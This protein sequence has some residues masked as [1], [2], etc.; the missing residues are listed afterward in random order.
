MQNITY[1][2]INN[3]NINIDLYNFINNEVVPGLNIKAEFFFTS[4]QKI[5]NK[6][7]KENI[8]LLE[9]RNNMQQKIDNWHI[10]NKQF[11][12]TK[13]KKF[14]KN[15]NY[16][17]PEPANFVIKTS[18]VDA[19]IKNI[20]GPQLVVPITNARFTVNAINARWGSLYN[21]LYNSDVIKNKDNTAIGDSSNAPIKA[22]IIKWSN[23]FLDKTLPLINATYSQLQSIHIKN[24]KPVFFLKNNKTSRLKNSS[25]FIA[26]DKKGNLLMK[27]NNLHIELLIDKNTHIIKDVILESAISTIVDFED[28]VVTVSSEEKIQAYR[29]FLGLIKQDLQ[30]TFKKMEKS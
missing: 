13:Y 28:S 8:S 29:N 17:Q 22:E 23:N 25:A 30:A 12:F 18:G 9:I 2:T 6:T 3:L 16:L 1:K 10:N 19:E 5:I 14:L 21:A 27:H 15:I 20:A 11:N 26:S 24:Y 7:T 4:L